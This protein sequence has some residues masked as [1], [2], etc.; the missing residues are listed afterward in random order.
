M[1]RLALGP[2]DGR[3]LQLLVGDRPILTYHYRPDTPQLEAPRPYLHPLHTVSGRLVSGFR[4]H[5]HPWHRGISW[6]L[7]HLGEHNLWGG[8]TYVS[9]QGYVQLPNNGSMDQ[10][11]ELE[12]G[13]TSDR[14]EIVQQ[15]RWHAQPPEG[16]AQG[17]EL[18]VEERRLAVS[19]VEAGWVLTQSL[20]LTNSSGGDLPL[21]SPTTHGRENAGY[22]GLF[23]RGP[24][25]WTGGTLVSPAGSGADEL[26]GSRAPW[27][28]FTG[29]H[30]QTLDSSTLL[31]VDHPD[32]PGHQPQWFARSEEFA[33]LN[34]APFFSTEVPFADGQTLTFRYAVVVADGAHLGE[35]AAV[36][37][38]AGR[39]ALGL[40]GDSN[41]GD[42]SDATG[43]T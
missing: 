41:D 18:V 16:S 32:N 31:M 33:A 17:A 28:A 5:D 30:D 40:P 4:P 7:P 39:A 3:A 10:L 14:V 27:M 15:L 19:L 35:A 1:T 22:G 25:D 9:G 12:V 20:E 36:L 21:G 2:D 37:A 13:G 26:R 34:P 38:A 8:P 6:S 24:R 11:G 29:R 43:A 23:W 42:D